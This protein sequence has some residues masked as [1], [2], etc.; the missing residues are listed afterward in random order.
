MFT[1]TEA[2]AEAIEFDFPDWRIESE[3]GDRF[4]TEFDFDPAEVEDGPTVD[5]WEAYL[6]MTWVDP[7]EVA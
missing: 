1:I 6:E 3:M 2:A 7:A 5:D 4:L